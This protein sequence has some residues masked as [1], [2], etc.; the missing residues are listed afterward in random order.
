MIFRSNENEQVIRLDYRRPFIVY[1]LYIT[2][3]II[4]TSLDSLLKQITDKAEKDRIVIVTYST[5]ED[6]W[7][8]DII[9]ELLKYTHDTYT[10]TTNTDINFDVIPSKFIK[11]KQL[12]FFKGL[13][14]K[15]IKPRKMI[16][17]VGFIYNSKVIVI[18]I[19]RSV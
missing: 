13:F 18:V 15:D 17:Q 7:F 6:N 12:T 19:G 8:N 1:Q 3:T 10:I 9:N 2:N 16:H 11:Q 4:T 5:L 14:V